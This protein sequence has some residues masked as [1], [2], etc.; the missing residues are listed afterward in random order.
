MIF[1]IQSKVCCKRGGLLLEGVGGCCWAWQQGVVYWPCEADCSGNISPSVAISILRDRFK[2]C[3]LSDWH[4]RGEDLRH[5]NTQKSPVLFAMSFGKTS[6]VITQCLES[7]SCANEEV[8][9]AI[10]AYFN[11]FQRTIGKMIAPVSRR[12]V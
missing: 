8:F 9:A 6:Q 12:D 5:R 2:W 7:A 3:C 1:H 10:S 11:Y 4:L